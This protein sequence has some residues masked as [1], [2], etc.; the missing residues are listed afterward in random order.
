MVQVIEL[1]P[2]VIP[3]CNGR[4]VSP[5]EPFAFSALSIESGSASFKRANLIMTHPC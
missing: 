5:F 4:R 2:V 1:T 3:C